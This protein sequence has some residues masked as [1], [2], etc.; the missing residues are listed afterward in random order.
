MFSSRLFAGEGKPKDAWDKTDIVAR[1]LIGSAGIIF[2][3]VL[4][5]GIHLYNRRQGE[6][7][8]LREKHELALRQIETVHR[9]LP[10]LIS[11]DQKVKWASIALIRMGDEELAIKVGTWYVSR[12]LKQ[13]DRE[14]IQNLM[15]DSD[16][17]IADVATD[18][19]NRY[20]SPQASVKPVAAMFRIEPEY[21]F[22]KTHAVSPKAAISFIDDKA[23]KHG[24]FVV[25]RGDHT[26]DLPTQFSMGIYLVTNEFFLKFV[27]D[28][29]YTTEHCGR[30]YVGRH[31]TNFS[32]RMDGVMARQHGIPKM[33]FCL[34]EGVSRL[35]GS[36]TM[37]H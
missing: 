18:A 6:I 11:E 17:F 16:R 10:Q 26:L 27:Q 21:W 12:L 37:R 35:L 22:R 30:A 25:T 9:F 3:V 29:G 4:G 33:N 28:G 34:G 14:T 32:A 5:I 1:V 24:E 31:V 8:N 13:E 20:Y 19:F 23:E 15:N 7:A 36:A 2:P